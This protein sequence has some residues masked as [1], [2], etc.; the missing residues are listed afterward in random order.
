MQYDSRFFSGLSEREANLQ[1]EPRFVPCNLLEN[2]IPT[3]GKA[4]SEL[5]E[6]PSVPFDLA[7]QEAPAIAADRFAVALCPDLPA[8]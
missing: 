3:I 4:S 2:R 1:K 7:Q 6:D 8:L 5:A